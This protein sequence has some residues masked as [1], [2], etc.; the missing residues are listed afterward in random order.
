MKD[1]R[2]NL[3]LALNFKFRTV[4]SFLVAKVSVVALFLLLHLLLVDILGH[5]LQLWLPLLLL[6][7]FF[8]PFIATKISFVATKIFFVAAKIFFVATEID[9]VAP[10]MFPLMLL[11]FCYSCF[12]L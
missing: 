8:L 1:L 6:L 7:A 11:L 5:S 12:N 2:P 4:S 10:K 3:R 9:F